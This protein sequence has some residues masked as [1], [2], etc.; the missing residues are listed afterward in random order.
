[1]SVAAI[2]KNTTISVCQTVEPFSAK[3]MKIIWHVR[4]TAAKII[5]AEHHPATLEIFW[6]ARTKAFSL[7]VRWAAEGAWP[8]MTFSF[9]L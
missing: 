4:K 3:R 8:A 1:M 2:T 7:F 6:T 9:Q 5:K